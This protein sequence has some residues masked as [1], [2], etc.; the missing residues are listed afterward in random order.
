MSKRPGLAALRAALGDWR[1]NA[2][3]V[4]LVVVPVALAL[5]DGSRVAVYGAALAAFVVWMAWFVLTAV[6][7]LER[8]DF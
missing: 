5:V 1:R 3:A 6:D 4:V 7:W 2:V 8:A